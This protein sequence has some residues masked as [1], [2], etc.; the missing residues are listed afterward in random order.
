MSTQD[1]PSRPSLRI[2]EIAI[3]NFRTFRERTVIPLR[4]KGG[5]ADAIA[6]FHGDNG[7]GKSNALAALDLFFQIAEVVLRFGDQ[8][9]ELLFAWDKIRTD[10]GARTFVLRYQDRPHDAE[11]PTV[12]EV[13]FVNPGVGRLFAVCT[14]SGRDVRVSFKRHHGGNLAVIADKAERDRLLSLFYAP[15]RAAPL[16]IL[17]ARRR[18]QQHQPSLQGSLMPDVLLQQLYQLRTS[19]SPG[20]REIWR[21]FVGTLQGFATFRGKEVSVEVTGVAGSTSLDI[22]VEE[23]GRTVLTLGELSSGEQQLLVLLAESLLSGAAV[24]AIQEPEISL[25]VKNQRIFRDILMNIQRGSFIDQIILE[26]H[27]PSFDGADVIRFYRNED[28][29]SRV[30]RAPSVNEERSAIK[31]K[32][33]EQGAKQ[34]WVT[35]DGYTQLPD[36]MREE[37]HLQRG[38][39]LWFLRGPHHWE[40]WPETELDELFRRDDEG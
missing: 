14:P 9:G 36:Q 5:E 28:G 22:I 34:R 29:T 2:E 11:G 4:G 32:A 24:L 38:G 10:L 39:D 26:S 8:E 21:V 37:L 13:S 35:S 20:G 33:E 31:A 15:S 17:D 12:V 7:S 1:P 6:V 16:A 25:D 27:V 19:R 23:R 3:T 30:E 40:A 18:V